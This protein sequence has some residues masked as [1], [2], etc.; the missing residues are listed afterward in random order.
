MRT[1]Q[2]FISAIVIFGCFTA[3]SAATSNSEYPAK[4]VRFIIGFSPGGVNDIVS[5]L[6]AHDLT[7]SLGQQVIVDNR[8]GASGTIA[9]AIAASATPDGHTI[10]LVPTSFAIDTARGA[11][12]PYRPMR[13]FDPVTLVGSSPLVLVV[14]PATGLKSV[15]EL[16]QLARSQP[17]Q[18]TF[19][20]AGNGNLTHVA[21]EMFASM[22]GIKVVA[23]AYKGGGA[24]LRDVVGGQV[25]FGVPTMPPAM[26]HIKAGRLRPL[27]VT[28]TKPASILPG[29]PPIAA[30][31]VPGYEVK[32]WW[33]V[34]APNG[35]PD[36]IIKRLNRE[37]QKSLEVPSV[38][39][40]LASLAVEP[41]G[42]S[43]DELRTF[44]EA[45]AKKWERVLKEAGV[46]L[47]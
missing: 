35:T 45:E 23:V 37:V 39:Q 2:R 16:I 1:F 6:L 3:A 7:K 13:D 20:H 12:L 46:K 14:N 21:G 15:R 42:G 4:P 9:N 47:D 10:L 19:A 22:S 40:R 17:G 36:V 44:L 30:E 8:A 34:L 31:G 11:K 41:I 24:A 18:L 27:G 5:R 32:A 43:P 38:S 25:Q 28:G 26:G 29:V 33:A